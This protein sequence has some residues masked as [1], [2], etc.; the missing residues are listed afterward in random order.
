MD[1]KEKEKYVAE[2]VKEIGRL[3]F[4][5]IDTQDPVELQKTVYKINQLS[6]EVIHLLDTYGL[7]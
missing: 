2:T 3:S 1:G 4:N 5:A 6:H 7:D